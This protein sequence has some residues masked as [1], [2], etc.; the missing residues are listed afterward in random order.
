MSRHRDPQQ[1]FERQGIHRSSRSNLLRRAENEG[2]LDPKACKH[3]R[4]MTN[5]LRR[6]MFKMS[7][8]VSMSVPKHI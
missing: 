4:K 1:N 7:E 8:Q 3:M 6:K 2:Q 5:H